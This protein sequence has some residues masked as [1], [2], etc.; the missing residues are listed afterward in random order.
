MK[1][2]NILLK[3]P[4][5]EKKNLE[6]ID[7]NSFF[8]GYLKLKKNFFTRLIK[9]IKMTKSY[10][11]GNTIERVISPDKKDWTNNPWIL[12][13]VK[14]NEK[15]MRFWFFIKRELDLTGLLVGIGPKAFIDF[16]NDNASDIKHN[17]KGIINYVITYINKFNCIVF[18]PSLLSSKEEKKNS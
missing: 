6:L 14:D 15:G 5:G 8:N 12:M 2:W 1:T 16:N 7:S 9:A 10:S 3:L 11:S 4:N 17:I 13:I 18:L